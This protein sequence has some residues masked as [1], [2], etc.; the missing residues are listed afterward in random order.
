[1]KDD[2]LVENRGNFLVLLVALTQLAYHQLYLYL[3]EINRVGLLGVA[4]NELRQPPLYL[5]TFSPTTID[6]IVQLLEILVDTSDGVAEPDIR[7]L[8]V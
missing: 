8:I 1:M 7:G 6:A 3:Q 4:N 5:V 2:R